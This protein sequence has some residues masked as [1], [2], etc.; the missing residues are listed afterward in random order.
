MEFNA[1]KSCDKLWFVLNTD[2]QRILETKF[3][4]DFLHKD[5]EE[6]LIKI[7]KPKSSIKYIKFL[8]DKYRKSITDRKLVYSYFLNEN[9]Q[10]S[11]LKM[12]DIKNIWKNND[13]YLYVLSPDNYDT[14]T[15]LTNKNKHFE[16]FSEEDD[17]DMKIGDFVRSINVKINGREYEKNLDSTLKILN[18]DSLVNQRLLEKIE[19]M[20]YSSVPKKI[21]KMT[22]II[23]HNFFLS[24]EET[25]VRL[26][27][28]DSL[29]FYI[30]GFEEMEY[31]NWDSI[32]AFISTISFDNKKE[33]VAYI[34]FGFDRGEGVEYYI[35]EEELGLLTITVKQAL[36]YI[37]KFGIM[38][39]GTSEE[40]MVE[41]EEAYENIGG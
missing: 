35:E 34:K 23:S 27:N 22:D 28:Y 17:I 30:D 7:D 1:A 29:M 19:T 8:L 3:D 38:S 2:T 37:K 25:Y 41:L 10:F 15:K 40:E 20:K 18:S 24:N 13:K 33:G 9:P 21:L 39:I 6:Y 11:V 4:R 32:G 31:G 14:V 26:Y 36:K 16:S 12:S 5:Y